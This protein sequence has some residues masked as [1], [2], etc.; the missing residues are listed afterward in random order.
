MGGDILFPLLLYDSVSEWCPVFGG[1][2]TVAW[3]GFYG[4]LQIL[5]MSMDVSVEQNREVEKTPRLCE[6][7]KLTSRTEDGDFQ[8]STIW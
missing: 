3:I 6:R 8:Y 1:G 5:K 4:D 7:D 2:G